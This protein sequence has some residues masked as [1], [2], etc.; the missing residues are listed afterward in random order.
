VRIR[1]ENIRYTQRLGVPDERLSAKED[2][3]FS[4]YVAEDSGLKQTDFPR[5]G[6]KL[7][8]KSLQSYETVLGNTATSMGGEEKTKDYNSVALGLHRSVRTF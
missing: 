1:F 3:P 8:I 2:I 6:F 4:C 7:P 5:A